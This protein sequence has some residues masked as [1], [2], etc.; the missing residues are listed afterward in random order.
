MVLSVSIRSELCLLTLLKCVGCLACFR[1]EKYHHARE[2]DLVDSRYPVHVHFV[3]TVSWTGKPAAYGVGTGSNGH[4][5]YK[6]SVGF[7]NKV[8]NNTVKCIVGFSF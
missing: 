4:K 5:N 1:R 2:T 8:H 3:T 6:N 7:L